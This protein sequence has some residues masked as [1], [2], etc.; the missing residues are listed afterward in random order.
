VKLEM[1]DKT[2]IYKIETLIQEI[3]KK[4]NKEYKIFSQV[5]KILKKEISKNEIIFSSSKSFDLVYQK[6]SESIRWITNE[7]ITAKQIDKKKGY[8]PTNKM[9]S[10]KMISEK[11]EIKNEKSLTISV[12]H[13]KWPNKI[14]KWNEGLNL[15]SFLISLREEP[16]FQKMIDV[17]GG[18][19]LSKKIIKT[20][21]SFDRLSENGKVKNLT[22][23]LATQ[24]AEKFIEIG[25]EVSICKKYVRLP[26]HI[27]HD[28][29]TY[30][31]L[32]NAITKLKELGQKN[33]ILPQK[34]EMIK[35]IWFNK[36]IEMKLKKVYH[37]KESPPCECF[38]DD[39]K[40]AIFIGYCESKGFNEDG[41]YG[42]CL[43]YFNSGLSMILTKR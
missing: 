13:V 7:E 38:V 23:K 32:K 34:T 33:L 4:L 1:V 8:E 27:Y 19:I 15:K 30:Q 11:I 31:M 35:E 28:N 6:E 14:T 16:E 9:A 25:L 2:K 36:D 17:L 39:S 26:D 40:K 22:F 12:P 18:I 43:G 41:N 29:E 42:I 20:C 37:F 24:L 3:N 10:R 5:H 21:D